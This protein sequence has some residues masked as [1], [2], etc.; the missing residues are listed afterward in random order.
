MPQSLLPLSRADRKWK[1]VAEASQVLSYAC[2]LTVLYIWL[3]WVFTEHP[4][5]ARLFTA[6]LPKPSPSVRRLNK[7]TGITLIINPHLTKICHLEP[8][9]WSCMLGW[10]IKQEPA[11]CP[12]QKIKI[13]IKCFSPY[14]T[15]KIW[16]SSCY[17]LNW[18]FMNPKR[19]KT[20]FSGNE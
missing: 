2:F 14:L 6:H 17:G 4:L 16:Q 8:A 18:R 15:H 9:G 7:C 12:G 1:A 5:Y 13:K 3:L 19:E 11:H 10:P 20:C